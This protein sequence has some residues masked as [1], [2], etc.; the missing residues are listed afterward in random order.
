MTK[1]GL[2]AGG[3]ILT[4]SRVRFLFPNIRRR[5]SILPLLVMPCWIHLRLQT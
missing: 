3:T 1:V 2:M 4:G 5:L